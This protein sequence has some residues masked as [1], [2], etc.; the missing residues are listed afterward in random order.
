MLATYTNRFDGST[1][2]DRGKK[3]AG[4]GE[5]GTGLRVPVSGSTLRP[6][7]R[8][9]LT[10]SATYRNWPVTSGTAAIGLRATAKGESTTGVSPPEVASI[11]KTDTL[12]DGT[13]AQ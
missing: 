10:E 11:L 4:H 8:P 13:S 5:P 3:S 6:W 1:M 7:T 2:I 9:G 12:P